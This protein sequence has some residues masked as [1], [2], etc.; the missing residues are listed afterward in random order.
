MTDEEWTAILNRDKSYD[1]TFFYGLNTTKK[2]KRPSCP[3]KHPNKENV[4]IFHSLDEAYAQG[5]VPCK[6]CCPDM[7]CWT[8]VRNELVISAKK[9]IEEQYLEKFSL[10]KLADSLYVN[11]SYLLRTFKQF[12]GNT[13]LEYHNMVRCRKST[14]YLRNSDYNLTYISNMV[15]YCSSSHYIHCFKKCYKC[16]PT[17]YRKELLANERI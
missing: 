2:I 10:K 8:G 3:S 6:N 13:L 17:Q 14:E 5:Y 11:E 7:S 15:G 12:T 16:T 9:L 1:G 4:V